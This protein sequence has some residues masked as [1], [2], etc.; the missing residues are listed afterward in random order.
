MA[1]DLNSCFFIGRLGRSPEISQAQ[2]G[3]TI[4]KFNL[5]VGETWPSEHTEWIKCV[6]FGKLAEVV[7]KYL[8]KGSKVMVNGRLH[9]NKWED[10]EG[11]ARYTTET[12]V[13]Q[14]QM[15]G[16]K[17]KGEENQAVSQVKQEFEA[18]DVPF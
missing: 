12:I 5:A 2:T 16:S 13:N 15:L 10:R 8:D 11:N 17:K 7:E 14:L 9:T 6:C 3:T 1:N 18:E 4:A